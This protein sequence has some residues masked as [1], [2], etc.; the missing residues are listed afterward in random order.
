[1]DLKNICINNLVELIKNL[2]PLLKE[3][4]INNTIKSIKTEAKK[5]IFK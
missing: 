1:M 3:E 2:P 4:L 5:K